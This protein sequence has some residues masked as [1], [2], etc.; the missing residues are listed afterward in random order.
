MW[1]GFR[2]A[3]VGFT[4]LALAVGLS[5]SEFRTPTPLPRDTNDTQ[6]DC[7]PAAA[8][9]VA[10]ERLADSRLGAF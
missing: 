5:V 10:F 8:S 2:L 7:V 4:L 3:L 6:R 1:F 9:P